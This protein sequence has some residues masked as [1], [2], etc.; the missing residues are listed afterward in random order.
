M[1]QRP[2][3]GEGLSR[4]WF[5]GSVV[6]A[7]AAVTLTTAGQAVPG[8]AALDVLGPRTPGR[9]T[10]LQRLPVNRTGGAAGV[11][12]L[13]TSADYRLRVT[14]AVRRPLE[15]TLAELL[16]RPRHSVDL[17]LTCVEGW[18]VGATWTGLRLADLLREAGAEPGSDVRV[19]SL[20]ARGPYRSSHLT[21]GHAWS[22]ATLLATA[23]EKQSLD[24][25]HG[26]PVRLL[27]PDRPGVL[28]TKWLREVVVL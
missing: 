19:E 23:V 16:T 4:R 5:L 25:D 6:G 20:E 17:P 2:Q 7:A 10:G 3:G 12:A 8:L 9:G 28:Q 15:L 1:S 22:S 24:L 21:A 26:Y 13:A 14:G 27:A 18:S 11:A